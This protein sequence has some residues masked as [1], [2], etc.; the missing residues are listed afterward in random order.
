M[1]EIEFFCA[2]LAAPALILAVIIIYTQTQ[3]KRPRRRY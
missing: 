2:C 1:N 3:A